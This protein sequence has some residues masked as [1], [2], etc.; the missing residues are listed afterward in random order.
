MKILVFVFHFPPMS[1]GGAVV[2]HDIVST[3]AK[4]NH[5]VTVLVPD[6]KWNGPKYIPFMDPRLNIIRVKVPFD[7]KIKIASRLCRYN[8]QKTGLK[9]AKKNKYD[10]VFTIFHPFHLIPTAAVSC[11]KKLGIPVI[12]KIDDAVYEKTFG[13]KS[14]QRWLEKTHNAKVL[15]SADAVLVANEETKKIVYDHYK[16]KNN[17]SILAN[18][19]E[20]SLFK[21]GIRKPLVVFS[22]VMYH[23]RGLDILLQ[24]VPKVIKIMPKTKFLLF[25]EGP[26][27]NQLLDIVKKNNMNE[28]VSF[29][30]WLDR[31]TL[32]DY[33]SEASIGIGPLKIS[34][35]TKNA[36]PIKVLEYMASSL[37]IIA[38]S[39]TLPSDILVD[40]KNGYFIESVDELAEKII[41]LLD[42]P[43]EREIMGKSSFHMVQKFS[44]EKI[45]ENMFT[46]VKKN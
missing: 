42:N 46:L 45:I 24:A 10:F 33:L 14:I 34:T 32:A 44:W 23:H 15:Q 8:L 41:Y 43:R 7:R 5:E 9:I 25:G 19:I 16:V 30:G 17:V 12:V 39:G 22:G 20:L 28:N 4:L 3:L 40:G 21:D 35:V 13:L 6:I 2:S 29:M 18:G 38:K 37:P 1:G 31:S 26:Q 11:A 27:K 36:L